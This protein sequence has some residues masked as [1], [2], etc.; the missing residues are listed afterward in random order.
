MLKDDDELSPNRDPL[1]K[2]FLEEER[3]RLTGDTEDRKEE[4]KL[5]IGVRE[6]ELAD[7]EGMW[8]RFEHHLQSIPVE[9][10]PRMEALKAIAF[11]DWKN[12][13]G[14]ELDGWRKELADMESRVV[15]GDLVFSNARDRLLKLLG[16]EAREAGLLP[17]VNLREAPL[18]P[19]LGR[20]SP[21]RLAKGALIPE[22]EYIKPIL[23]SLVEL[24]GSA[25]GPEVLEI[26]FQK[27]KDRLS[28]RDLA[29]SSAERSSPRW[30]KQAAWCRFNLVRKYKF[31]NSDSPRGVWEINNKGRNYLRDL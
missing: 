31:L 17:R 16:A 4:L 28:E 1:L 6:S 22:R 23:E 14:L 9:Q 18:Q 20:A 25:K 7:V 15:D 2:N 11:V 29:L 21:I 3:R 27:M 8:R 12:S 19:T 30:R 26:I 5:F 24:G 10:R 13:Q